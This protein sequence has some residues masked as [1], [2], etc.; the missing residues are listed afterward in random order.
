MRLIPFA[1]IVAAGSIPALTACANEKLVGAVAGAAVGI[2]AGGPIGAVVGAGMGCL[3]GAA[4]QPRTA[5]RPFAVGEALPDSLTYHE[6]PDFPDYQ[7]VVL[8]G[9]KII[10]DR[11]WRRVLRVIS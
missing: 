6:I 4:L 2:V 5:R 11:R 8:D 10:V 1:A 7:Y 3:V 9:S